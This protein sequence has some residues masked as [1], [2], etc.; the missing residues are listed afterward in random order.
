VKRLVTAVIWALLFCLRPA[1]VAVGQSNGATPGIVRDQSSV[2]PAPIALRF[3]KMVDGTGTVTTDAV[4][5]VNGEGIVS[6]GTGAAAIPPRATVIDLKRLTAIPGLIDVHTHLT[7][8]WDQAPGTTPYRQAAQLPAETVFLSQ[9]NA[10]KTLETGVTSVRD[11]MANDSMDIAMRNLINRGAMVGPRMFVA[12]HGLGTRPGYVSPS[13]G[14]ANGVAEMMRVTR[15]VIASGADWVKLFASTGGTQNLT[16]LQV[17]TFDEIKAAV[18]VA[19]M[20]GKRVAVHSYGPA[21]AKDAVKAGV[22]TL[23]HAIDLDGETLAEMARRGTY[24]VPTIDHNRFYADNAASLGFPAGAAERYGVFIARNLETTRQALKA[25][26][27]VA[28]GSDAVYTMFGQNT[29]EL[30]WLVKAGMTPTQA[31]AA[32]TTT[33]AALLGMEKS[34]GAS[35]PGFYADIAAVEGDPLADVDVVT[36]RVRWVMKGGVVVVDKQRPAGSQ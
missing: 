17:L 31:L 24:Y 18:D 7:R 11:L 36:N 19:H 22:D 4:V 15:E 32:A 26:V 5:V 34:L 1:G 20:L 29:R 13:G 9:E 16:G 27:R 3:G 30:T 21:A 35:A 2:A 28:M 12:S 8:Y 14:G 25:G 23:E 6:V 10:R 33:G